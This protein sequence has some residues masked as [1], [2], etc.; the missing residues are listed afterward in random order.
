MHDLLHQAQISVAQEMKNENLAAADQER[1]MV[2]QMY[3]E[4]RW[5]WPLASNIQKIIVFGL[6]PPAAWVMAAVVEN[7]LF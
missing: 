3:L 2:K 4:S 1:L 7:L 6:L 5:E